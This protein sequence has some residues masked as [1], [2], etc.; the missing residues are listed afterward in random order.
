MSRLQTKELKKSMKALFRN[1]TNTEQKKNIGNAV[2]THV[3][4]TLCLSLSQ[5]KI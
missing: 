3:A 2:E 5:K 1:I 4:C